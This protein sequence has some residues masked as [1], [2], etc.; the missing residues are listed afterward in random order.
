[1]VLN[2]KIINKI[3][4]LIVNL[5]TIAT[6]LNW[7]I[8]LMFFKYPEIVYTLIE[9]ITYH[10]I[11]T[12]DSLMNKIYGGWD[13]KLFNF[14]KFLYEFESVSMN[15]ILVKYNDL[16]IDKRTKSMYMK[17]YITD[18]RIDDIISDEEW[19]LP[20]NK[21]DTSIIGNIIIPSLI[22]LVLFTCKLE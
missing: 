19:N 13:K 8:I 12:I 17:I 15:D 14:L 1:M 9:S 6:F 22:I 3:P 7:V 10:S 21:E 18:C 4:H 16:R 5:S 11:K 20:E 2:I